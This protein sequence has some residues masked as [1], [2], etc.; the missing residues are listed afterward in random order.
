MRFGAIGFADD[1]DKVTKRSHK[2]VS[3][4][5]RLLLE[6]LVAG[7][8][9]FLIVD[10]TGTDLYL[11]FFS[12]VVIPM[13]PLYYAFAMVLIVGFGSL[14]VIGALEFDIGWGYI[15]AMQA[16]GLD[17]FLQIAKTRSGGSDA[18]DREL[19]RRVQLRGIR[20]RRIE[21]I[22]APRRQRRH[23]T[24]NHRHIVRLQQIGQGRARSE[25]LCRCA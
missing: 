11:P 8:V 16:H 1:Y 23:R 22:L 15:R 13:G 2:G 21:R 25:V 18:E 12:N 20:K 10:R 14:I 5:V 3:G 6:F 4:K 24:H 9:V 17:N 7:I 19:A